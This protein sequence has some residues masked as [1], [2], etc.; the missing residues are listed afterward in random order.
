MPARRKSPSSPRRSRRRRQT[1]PRQSSGKTKRTTAARRSPKR[2]TYSG[3]QCER[4]YGAV[5]TNRVKELCKMQV[6]VHEGFVL[7]IIGENAYQAPYSDTWTVTSKINL[8]ESIRQQLENVHDD[9]F[10]LPFYP[11][12]KEIELAWKDYMQESDTWI[13]KGNVPC[14]PLTDYVADEDN[15]DDTPG[16]YQLSENTET[17]MY[18][19]IPTFVTKCKPL[20]E[21]FY[22]HFRFDQFEDRT[23]YHEGHDH[24]ASK[25]AQH[26]FLN[27]QS[28]ITRR[29]LKRE[30]E[31]LQRMLGP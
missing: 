28:K 9:E 13:D 29:T 10:T 20:Q 26:V 1:S 12:K 19:C 4:L 18:Y 3:T 15:G 30:A 27:P 22:N 7:F 21:R 17:A 16:W 5:D 23:P 31:E 25:I 24:A 11:T 2:R 6:I 8:E 14:L